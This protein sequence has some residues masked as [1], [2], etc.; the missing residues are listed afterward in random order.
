MRIFTP[1]EE[2]PMAGHPTIGS[3]FALAI[4]GVISPRP[5]RFVFELGVGPDAGFA[6]MGRRRPV[7][8]LDDAAAADLRDASS[9]TAIAFAAAVGISP[10]DLLRACPCRACPAAFRFSS[11]RSPVALRSTPSRSTGRRWHAA[12]HAAGLDELPAFFFTPERAGGGDETVYSRMLAPGFGIRRI[13]RLAPP[14]VRSAAYLL[15][16]G[17]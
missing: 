15:H 10:H 3:T 8:R 2:L 9:P 12:L 7:V 5:E 14:A 6:R 11:L 16:H 1:G 4:E 13:R 17:S